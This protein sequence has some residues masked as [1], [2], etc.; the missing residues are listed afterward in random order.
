[1]T[2]SIIVN[3]EPI[4]I[5]P[6]A[7]YNAQLTLDAILNRGMRE[8]SRLTSTCKQIAQ[9]ALSKIGDINRKHV[10]VLTNR[11]VLHAHEAVGA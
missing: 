2:Q 10:R 3:V 1:M 4:D 11:L 6:T 8:P 7:L 9:V 5:P